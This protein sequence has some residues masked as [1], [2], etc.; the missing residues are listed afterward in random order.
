MGHRTPL[1]AI[2]TDCTVWQGAGV[3]CM[4]LRGAR[5]VNNASGGMFTGRTQVN[6]GVCIVL[7]ALLAY[8]P[9]QLPGTEP[10]GIQ[11]MRISHCAGQ[12]PFANHARRVKGRS[13]RLGVSGSAPLGSSGWAG[14]SGCRALETG[15]DSQRWHDG[16]KP[17]EWQQ[18]TPALRPGFSVP[19]I[20]R[21]VVS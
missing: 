20:N 19:L 10:G 3:Q 14:A 4:K 7:R 15:T 6:M 12:F 8:D 21:E 13:I 1:V 9:H 16:G 17:T 18:R 5:A 11:S 2:L